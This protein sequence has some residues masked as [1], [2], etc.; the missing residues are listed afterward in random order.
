MGGK[1][2]SQTGYRADSYA[3]AERLCESVRRYLLY[4]RIYTLIYS[5]FWKTQ[6]SLLGILLGSLTASKLLKMVLVCAWVPSF[7]LG[8]TSTLGLAIYYVVNSGPWYTVKLC[9]FKT[10]AQMVTCSCEPSR[11]A[12]QGQILHHLP[13]RSWESVSLQTLPCI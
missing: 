7:S 3:T 10:A 5:C 2:S 8:D 9:R 13:T 4:V 6:T 1:I 12:E 11:G